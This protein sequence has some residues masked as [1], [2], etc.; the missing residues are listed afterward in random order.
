VKT[1]AAPGRTVSRAQVRH[2]PARR[3]GVRRACS[4]CFLVGSLV[5]LAGGCQ[6]KDEEGRSLGGGS[7]GGSGGK[8]GSTAIP[9]A[10]TLGHESGGSAGAPEMPPDPDACADL[11][12]LEQCGGAS[13]KAELKTVNLLIVID[14]SGSMT[15]EPEGFETDKWSAMK[16]ALETVLGSVNERVHLGLALYPYSLGTPI[17]LDVCTDNCCEVPIGTDAVVVDI[18]PPT[19]SGPAILTKLSETSPGGGTPTA[20][21]LKGAFDYFTNGLGATL[22]GGKYVLL[23]TDGGPN[24]NPNGACGGDE[25]TPNLDGWC[26]DNGNCCDDSVNCC[27]GAGEYCV[28]ESGVT[29]QIEALAGAGIATFVVGIPGTDAYADYLDA[30]ALS[31]GVPNT[32]GDRDYFAVSASAGVSGLVDVFTDITTDLVTSCEIALE[33]KPQVLDSVNVAVDCQVIP[34]EGDDGSGWEYDQ[35]PDPSSVILTGSACE[36]L[37]ENGASRIDV[38]YGCPTVR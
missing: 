22:E 38:I 29:E 2:A 19:V 25:C 23:A 26:D 14:K 35:V 6:T 30:F 1:S 7:G 17:P 36:N 31:G 18:G 4:A 9:T 24:C 10:G 20:K 5:L 34:Q 32:S 13:V 16:E 11:G 8:A 37:K 33:T 27:E 28:D 15:D 3:L 21:A 12:G